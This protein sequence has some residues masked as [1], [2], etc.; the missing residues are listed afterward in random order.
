MDA[1][2]SIGPDLNST[3]LSVLD[4]PGPTTTLDTG[5]GGVELLLHGVEAAV[6]GIN[7]LGQGAR[8]RL[9]ST[10]GLRSEVFPEEGVVD[11]AA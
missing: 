2:Y 9:T 7:G 6:V 5:E 11:M 8:W 3:G 1:T 10:L 4:Q